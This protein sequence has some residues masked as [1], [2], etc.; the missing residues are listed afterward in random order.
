MNSKE[1]G[2]LAVGFAISYF[3][4]EG[5]EVC[6]PIGDKRA[7]DLVVEKHGKF[8]AVQVKYAG[9]YS[10]SGKCR[11]GLRVTGGNQSYNYASKYSD[12]EFDLLFIYSELGT[13]YC[14]PWDEVSVRNEITIEDK[15]YLK[16]K[17]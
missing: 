6:L 13:R 4:A 9:K 8:S 12:N 14:I 5:Y 17:C 7:W 1:K 10:S 15:K 11:A 2:D 3:I 16:Y